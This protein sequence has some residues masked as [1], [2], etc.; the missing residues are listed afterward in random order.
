MDSLLPE[1]LAD[2]FRRESCRKLV[3]SELRQ[4]ASREFSRVT[5]HP[6]VVQGRAQWQF[7][8]QSRDRAS[9]LNLETPAAL[10]RIGELV[11]TTFLQAGLNTDTAVY[12]LRAPRH[13]HAAWKVYETG[14]PA[15]APAI[16]PRDSH[17]RSKAYLIPEGTPCAFLAEM[18]VMT[19]SGQVR[20]PMYAKF[21]Q[22]NR[23]LELVRDICHALPANRELR[24]IDFGCGKSYLTFALHHL[25]TIVEQRQVLITG[26]DLKNDVIELCRSTISR[27]GLAGLEFQQ[28]SIA[29]FDP[30]GPVD[31][32]VSLHACD[33]ATDDA[34]AQAVAWKARA[35]LAVPCCQHELNPILQSKPLSPLM[36]HG[37]LK[38][39]FAAL[40]TDALRALVLEI[41]GYSTQVVEFIDLEHTP[42]NLLLR[43][44]RREQTSSD[45]LAHRQ[46]EL[47]EYK[48]AL[49]LEST[50]L[51]RCL[52]E[53]RRSVPAAP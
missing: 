17:N 15:P 48:Q 43:A 32:V 11:T 12:N 33:T 13:Q 50:H 14:K 44:V 47:A 45:L 10:A 18:G 5:V 36:K 23:F 38:E 31:L 40:A 8:F 25:F 26:L 42:K 53:M 34:L 1:V 49:G 35:I 20:R 30:N 51:E 2:S 4:G 19:E 21:R 41:E 22:V 16:A 6:V 46:S 39:R 37:I 28:G 24:I 9:H 27:L 29:E 52:V 3:L 7:T